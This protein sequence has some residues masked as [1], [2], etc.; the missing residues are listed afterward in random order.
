M[1]KHK[2]KLAAIL[3]LI[4]FLGILSIL[5]MDIALPPEA[6]EILKAQFTPGQIKLLTLINP[7]M[8]LVLSVVIGTIFYDTVD[9]KVPFTSRILDSTQPPIKIVE[10]L[11]F[12]IIGGLVS[13]VLLNIVGLVYNP[14]LPEEFKEL[15]ESI[16]PSLA[17]RF[18]YGGITEE[19][20]MRFGLMTFIVWGSSKLFGG[21]KSYVYWTGI[22]LSAVLF[23]LGHFPIAY[24]TLENPS[25]LLLSYILLGNSIGGVIFGWLYWKKGL[26]SAFLAHIFTH[27]TLLIAA[28]L[29]I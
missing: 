20:L 11:K 1:N 6:E 14:I 21:T 18:L 23:A 9:L 17:T 12:G 24:Q 15:G 5:T 25:T 22:L 10:I 28:P 27:V 19:I 4:G 13:G 8:M 29:L 7:T 3:L 16:K 26:E 2:F